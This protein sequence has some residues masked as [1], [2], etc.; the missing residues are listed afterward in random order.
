ML[1]IYRR[2]LQSYFLS[3][4]AYIFIGFFMLTTGCFFVLFNILSSSADYVSML[5][6][7]WFQFFIIMPLSI[8]TMRLLS[9]ERR[10][11][12][13]QLLLTSPLSITSMVLGKYFAAVTVFLVTI[14]VSLIFPLIL[15]FFGNPAVL[16]I[17]T[18][19]I[20]FFLMGSA[21]IAVGVFISSLTEN[22]VISA[23]ATFGVLLV[24]WLLGKALIPVISVGWIVDILAWL[25][26]YD[27]FSLFVQ[28]LVS[29]TQIFYYI[30]FAA[31]FIFLTVRTVESRR[32]SEV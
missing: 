12:T 18:G 29:I 24:L 30:S 13:D 9:E 31:V 19:Y 4:L 10:N 14:I 15:S 7:I 16:E 5:G 17:I 8:L 26:V 11:K 32:W 22:Q 27:R 23:V 1:A 25:S 2:E 21:L 28:G 3:P 20:G 6:S